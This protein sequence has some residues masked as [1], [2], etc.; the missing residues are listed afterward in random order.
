MLIGL[1]VAGLRD[2]LIGYVGVHSRAPVQAPHIESIAVLP[3]EN[4]SHDPEQEYFADG[5]TDALITDLGQVA[6]LRVISRTSVMQYKGAKKPLPQIAQELNVDAVVEGTVQRS[7]NRVRITAQLL[8]ARTDTHLWA[9]DL[10]ARLRR[11]HPAG[12]ADGAGDR[13][14]SQRAAD[15]RRRD[16]PG[17]QAN[18]QSAR[19]RCLPPRPLSLERENCG[20]R[21][22]EPADTSSRRCGK[23]PT[24]R[25]PTPA[26]LIAM[27]WAGG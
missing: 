5:L 23:I 27:R 6:P 7:G 13:P 9:R 17:Q 4:L 19:L 1:K 3:L 11:S 22:V 25:S 10:R 2:R 14:R 18:G 16:A 24:S 12:G 20:N 8:E 15:S 21:T 26:W